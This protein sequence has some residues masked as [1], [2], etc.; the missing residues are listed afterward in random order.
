[1]SDQV[2]EEEPHIAIL[3]LDTPI[4]K[5]SEVYGDFGDQTIELLTKPSTPPY[6]LKKYQ[7]KNDNLEELEK[8]YEKLKKNIQSNLIHGFVLTGSGCDAF[9]EYKWLIRF[10]SFLKNVIINLQK[11][12]VGICFG[13]QILALVLGCKIDRNNEGWEL[14]ITT[15]NLNDE[16]YK[17]PNSPFLELNQRQNIDSL[18]DQALVLFEH[19]NLIEFHQDIIYGGIPQ[20]FV[21][22]GSTS[23]CSIQGMISLPQ[24]PQQSQPIEEIKLKTT[25]YKILT[26]QGHPEFSTPFALELLKYKFELGL[27]EENQ[28]EKAKYHTMSLNNQGDLIGKV[29][30]K[31]LFQQDDKTV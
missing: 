2:I 19:L 14:G 5:I 23:K 21:N 15:I 13:H 17:I 25:N 11:P 3:V 18:D 27:L 12:I 9:G 10:K 26:F 29:I 7:L 8:V 28:Y 24:Q 22:F 6:Q 4:P 30:C 20:G 1:M 31:F 16:I